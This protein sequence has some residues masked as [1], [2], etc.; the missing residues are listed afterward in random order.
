MFSANEKCGHTYGTYTRHI[1]DDCNMYFISQINLDFIIQ[2]LHEESAKCLNMVGPC[3]LDYL[4][5]SS[6]IY[7][8][9]YCPQC[10]EKINIA[11]LGKLLDEAE[12]ASTG[13]GE[14]EK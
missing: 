1:G 10:G 8:F 5:Q 13:D 9:N 12:K 14:D 4:K 11:K 6:C 7:I 2:L 3:F